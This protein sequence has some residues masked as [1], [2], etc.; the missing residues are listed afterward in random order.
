M[1]N[2]RLLLKDKPF[3]DEAFCRD[4]RR[5]FAAQGVLGDRLVFM[6]P[7]SRE[8]HFAAYNRVDIA[9]DPTPYG[10]TTTADALWMG[11]PVV[12]LRGSNW[13]GRVSASILTT[14]GCTELIA[15]SEEAYLRIATELA[16]DVER[17]TWLHRHLRPMLEGSPF[18]D[19]RGFTRD[20]EAAFRG[21]WRL[22]CG[23]PPSA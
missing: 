6:G 13:V 12:T 9:L 1:P 14:L 11:V 5:R 17:R 16:A 22:W 19:G 18:C 20:L 23:V 3:T 10:G 4:M 8:A 21:M 15:E 7:V 2:A